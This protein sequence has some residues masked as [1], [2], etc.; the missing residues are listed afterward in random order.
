M[1]RSASLIAFLLLLCAGDLQARTIDVEPGGVYSNLEAAAAVV[2][3]GDTILFRGGVYAGGQYVERLQGREDAWITI[4]VAPGEEAIVRG[5]GNGWQLVDGAYIRCIGFVIEDQTGNG[6]N[7]DDGG[8][9]DTPA[10]HIVIERCE[11]RGIDATG[12]NDLLKLSGLDSFEVR[13]CYFH[14]GAAGGSMVDMVGCH[15]GLFINNRFERAGSNAIQAKGG[16]SD[17]RIER[18]TF[19]DGGQRGIN[20]GGST[21]LQFFRPSGVPYESAEIRVYS[22]LFV[23]SQAPVAFVGTVNSE[24]VNNTI[25]LPG[26][27]AIRILQETT[28]SGFLQCGDNIFRN[29]IVVVDNAAASPTLNIGSN[30]RPET[31]TFSNNLWYNIQNGGWGGPNLPS[32]EIGGIIGSN[33]L[34]VAPPDSVSLLGGSPAIGKGYQVSEPALDYLGR[35][36]AEPRSIGA[37]EGSGSTLSVD[38]N[39]AETK[40]TVTLDCGVIRIDGAQAHDRIDDIALYDLRG[41]CVRRY[42][43]RSFAGERPI[44][45]PVDDVSPGI[46]LCRIRGALISFARLIPILQ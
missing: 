5:G 26:K 24:V 12:N 32:V 31:F 1:T 19:I 14:D 28:E 35:P 10:H 8:S 11:W 17:I 6:W 7:F 25:W 15:D 33:P 27:W 42:E 23:R 3:P 18:N 38:G 22:N 9:Y 4:M 21:G 29:N 45:I 44:A 20:I 43:G 13:G 36:F 39:T 2:V 46:Y 16:S 30:T 34:L 40:I 41:V 37:I